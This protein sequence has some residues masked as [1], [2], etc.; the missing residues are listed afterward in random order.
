LLLFK[1]GKRYGVEFK[2]ADAPRL[3]L[4]MTTALADLKLEHLA[5]IYPGDRRYSL[6]ERVNVVPA[7]ELGNKDAA[8]LI[9]PHFRRR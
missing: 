5:V 9:T 2:R 8:S 1:N 6:A 4:S 3:T 7:S